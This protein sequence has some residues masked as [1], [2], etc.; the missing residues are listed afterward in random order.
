MDAREGWSERG[1][2]RQSVCQKAPEKTREKTRSNV[3]SEVGL[4]TVNES[5]GDTTTMSRYTFYENMRMQCDDECNKQNKT[6]GEH[7]IYGRRLEHRFWG[8]TT[9]HHYERISSRDL[10]WHQSEKRKRKRRGKTKLL[11]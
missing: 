7:E 10:E 5:K 1:R 11:L 2:Q 3:A 9:L 6:H 4:E 8:V